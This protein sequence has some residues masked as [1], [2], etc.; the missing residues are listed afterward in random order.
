MGNIEA[1][2]TVIFNQEAGNKMY[3]IILYVCIFPEHI[4][5]STKRLLFS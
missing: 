5:K 3:F 1:Q 4:I 2:S